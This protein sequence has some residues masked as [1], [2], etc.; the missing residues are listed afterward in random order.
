MT[1]RLFTDGRATSTLSGQVA[2]LTRTMA[3]QSPKSGEVIQLT[4]LIR[5]V[6]NYHQ[7][8]THT[9]GV[10]LIV[11]FYHHLRARLYLNLPSTEVSMV[12]DINVDG[13]ACDNGSCCNFADFH[14]L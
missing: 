4:I 6:H 5:Q 9:V 14:F 12:H 8:I 2:K 13:D 7:F 3:N 10:K 1:V 11:G